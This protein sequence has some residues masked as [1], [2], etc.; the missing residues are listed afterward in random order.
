MERQKHLHQAQ[1]KLNVIHFFLLYACESW[2]LTA[3]L[4]RKTQ[5]MEMRCFRRLLGISYRDRITNEEVKRRIQ[6][7]IGPYT[8]I[9]TSVKQRKLKWYGHITRSSSLAKTFLQGT[10]QGRRPRGRPRKR[11]EDNITEW[12]GLK[13]KD[14]LRRTECRDGWRRLVVSSST[15]TFSYSSSSSRSLLLSLLTSASLSI[16]TISLCFSNSLLFASILSTFSL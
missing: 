8:D 10:V 16:S 2:T 13:L 1:N 7:Q 14:L 9:L 6:N 3:E 11:W 4:E 15:Y 12:T 5:A